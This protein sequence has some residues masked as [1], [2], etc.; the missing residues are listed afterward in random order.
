[1]AAE[2]SSSRRGGVD[3]EEMLRK[4]KL[5]EGEKEG[6]FLAKEERSGL[7]EVKWMAVAKLLSVRIL[8]FVLQFLPGLGE[9]AEIRFF[10]KI[11][12]NLGRN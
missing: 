6:V 3:V 1:M 8:D 12:E 5:S 2:S 11:S 4:L 9:M 7:P 10:G